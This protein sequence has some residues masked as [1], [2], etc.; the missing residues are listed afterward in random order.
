MFEV[1]H[2]I[3]HAGPIIFRFFLSSYPTL[4]VIINRFLLIAISINQKKK[5]SLLISL[6]PQVDQSFFQMKNWMD[7]ID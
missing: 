7:L 3:T 2:F 1:V 4:I 5:Q 6:K